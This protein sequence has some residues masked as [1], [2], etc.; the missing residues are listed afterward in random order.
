MTAIDG[1]PFAEHDKKCWLLFLPQGEDHDIGLLFSNY[2]IRLSGQKTIYLGSEVPMESLK[3]VS[4]KINFT[5]VLFFMVK[6]RPVNDAQNYIKEL[7]KIHK[8]SKVH[9][10]GNGKLIGELS[11]P[12]NMD[13]IQSVDQL[14]KTYLL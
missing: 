9:L 13:W 7:N 8:N 10:T 4:E 6:N 5:D 11:L 2:L 3:Q 14:E 12:N 1:L